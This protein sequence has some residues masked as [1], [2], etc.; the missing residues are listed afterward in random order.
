MLQILDA[1]FPFSPSAC[2]LGQS[3]HNIYMLLDWIWTWE[4][5]SGF[6]SET[7]LS[8]GTEGLIPELR[9]PFRLIIID[10]LLIL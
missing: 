10:L 6:L 1:D 3:P 8:E 7:H 2:L 9:R 5:L 4:H